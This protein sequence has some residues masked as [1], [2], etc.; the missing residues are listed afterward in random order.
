VFRC[1][2]T[3]CIALLAGGQCLALTSGMVAPLLVSTAAA[4]AAGVHRQSMKRGRDQ[5]DEYT[6]MLVRDWLERSTLRTTVQTFD[7]ECVRLDREVPG[8]SDWER[9]VE[10]L[11]P[12]CQAAGRRDSVAVKTRPATPLL[13]LLVES[14]LKEQ[15]LSSG[16][17]NNALR[18][19]RQQSTIVMTK[20]TSASDALS[21]LH[22]RRLPRASPAEA[23]GRLSTFAENHSKA[24]L[25][26]PSSLRPKSAMV[27]RSM[28]DLLSRTSNEC[29]KPQTDEPATTSP[30]LK[31]L[32]RPISAAGFLG[33]RSGSRCPDNNPSRNKPASGSAD[34][35]KSKSSQTDKMTRTGSFKS[36]VPPSAHHSSTVSLAS[37][38]QISESDDA[39]GVEEREDD[40]P[41]ET[42]PAMLLEEM[43]EELLMSQFS[44][45]SKE[46]IKTIRRVRAKSNAYNQEYEKAKRTVDKIQLREKQRQIRRVLA[47]EQT[48]L[49]SSAMDGLTNEPCALCEHVFP[50]KSLVMKVTYKAIFDLRASWAS[51]A[52]TSN[53]RNHRSD[54][55]SNAPP[56]ASPAVEAEDDDGSGDRSQVAH[57]YDE[58]PICVFCKQLVLNVSL[59]R[60]RCS[61]SW[62]VRCVPTSW[63]TRSRSSM[64]PTAAVVRGDSSQTDRDGKGHGRGAPTTGDRPIAGTRPLRPARLRLVPAQQRRGQRHGGGARV[65]RR[66]PPA[67]CAAQ[68]AAQ[69]PRGRQ[70]RARGQASA[71]RQA[72]QRVGARPEQQGVAAD[73]ELASEDAHMAPPC[74][75]QIRAKT[76][77]TI[78]SF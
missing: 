61:L 8:A 72:A 37:L 32:P 66:R 68:K 39:M 52:N 75:R 18:L 33:D 15:T 13:R 4:H 70:S 19:P 56:A 76:Q 31:K 22:K 54:T 34:S 28:S 17:S 78:L 60:V 46:A 49:L 63:L 67:H 29:A 51:A 41:K 23:A 62:M 10:L 35:L 25:G 47:A 3:R 58:V 26:S 21:I 53:R 30:S 71:L 7:E 36:L 12:A 42:A 27:C 73:H 1:Q 77:L 50:K 40:Q 14:L 55:V 59:Y 6:A 38:P 2:D 9:L 64:C 20:R 5:A 69:D 43:S 48:E 44:S 16:T 11:Q 65:R 24:N 74:C 45:L 57:F